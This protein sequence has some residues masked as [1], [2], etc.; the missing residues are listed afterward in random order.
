MVAPALVYQTADRAA[1]GVVYPGHPAGADRDEL[2]RLGGRGH[3]RGSHCTNGCEFEFSEHFHLPLISCSWIFEGL[4]P[5]LEPCDYY[6]FGGFC[7]YT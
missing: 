3:H 7:A 2:F 1:G 4:K 6:R 5:W